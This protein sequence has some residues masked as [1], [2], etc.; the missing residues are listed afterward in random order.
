VDYAAAVHEILEHEHAPP[1]GAKFVEG[2]MHRLVDRHR[3][4]AARHLEELAE[5]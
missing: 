1:T 5:G 3:E 2:P 4:K